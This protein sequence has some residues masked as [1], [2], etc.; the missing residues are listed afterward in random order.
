MAIKAGNIVDLHFLSGA[1]NRI[2]L[3]RYWHLF[4][5][6]VMVYVRL[7]SFTS[8]EFVFLLL[9]DKAHRGLSNYL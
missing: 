5:S 7:A 9:L 2:T 4:L 3:P 8:G 1:L 6:G